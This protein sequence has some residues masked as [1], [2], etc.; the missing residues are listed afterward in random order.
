MADIPPLASADISQAPASPPLT[1]LKPPEDSS[2][3][4][5]GEASPSDDSL[6]CPVCQQVLYQPLTTPCNHSFCGVC[7]TKWYFNSPHMRFTPLEEQACPAERAQTSKPCGL[8]RRSV[9]WQDLRLDAALHERA[10]QTFPQ[11]SARRRA[12]IEELARFQVKT[13]SLYIGNTH[14]YVFEHMLTRKPNVHLWTFFVHME[15]AEEEQRLIDRV[16]VNLHPTFDPRSVT[17]TQPPFEVRRLGWGYFLINVQ[18]FWK[19]EFAAQT[20]NPSEYQ[21][22][23][24]F[25]GEGNF[26][27]HELTFTIPT[28]KETDDE[29]ALVPLPVISEQQTEQEPE[30]T[31]ELRGWDYSADADEQHPQVQEPTPAAS[32]CPSNLHSPRTPAAATAGSSSSSVTVSH[33]EHARTSSASDDASRP[34]THTFLH[35][36]VSSSS[37]PYPSVRS[38]LLT[39]DSLISNSGRSIFSEEELD[40]GEDERAE[41]ERLL[42]TELSGV[43]SE[44]TSGEHHQ[45]LEYEDGFF[46]EDDDAHPTA[47]EEAITSAGTEGGDTLFEWRQV[48][49]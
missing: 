35:T 18:I 2:G 8:C 45:V 16:V 49:E 43:L 7:M 39:S 14:T 6:S 12:E 24:D 26:E 27:R 1:P 40:L 31:V 46:P 11:E 34:R 22:Q 33:E 23:L 42:E 28:S 9:A 5:A 3:T 21:W 4:R 38:R 10:E 19:A 29:P 47:G 44:D 13:A 15:D 37:S 41:M 48:E 20:S 25:H 36:S 32:A 30:H 17:L